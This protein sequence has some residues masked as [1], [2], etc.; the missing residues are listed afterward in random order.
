MKQRRAFARSIIHENLSEEKH[1][2]RYRDKRNKQQHH[3]R[4]RKGR[5]VLNVGFSSPSLG[6]QA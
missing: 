5:G 2:G 3:H 4:Y 6:R 1:R